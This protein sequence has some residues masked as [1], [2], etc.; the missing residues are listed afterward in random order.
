MY[1]DLEQ[2]KEV[3]EEALELSE[4]V[5]C[6]RLK[7]HV[8]EEMSHAYLL[9]E[10]N[11]DALQAAE[12]S[13]QLLKELGADHDEITTRLQVLTKVLIIQD[14]YREAHNQIELAKE[15]SEACGGHLLASNRWKNH[16]KV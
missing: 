3:S 2:A 14:N 11:N 16:E 10:Q 15:G 13:V 9:A 7:A 6:K 8:W 5:G 1:G 4:E 12:L